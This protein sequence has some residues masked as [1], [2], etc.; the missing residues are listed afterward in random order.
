[1]V[2]LAI[3][4]PEAHFADFVTSASMKGFVTTTRATV[5]FLPF[6][7]LGD[8]FRHIVFYKLSHYLKV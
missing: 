4:F 2:I 3:I 6:G 5:G 8:V 1:M 7:G